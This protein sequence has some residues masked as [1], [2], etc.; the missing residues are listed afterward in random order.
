MADADQLRSALAVRVLEPEPEPV[1]PIEPEAE[2]VEPMEPDEPLV[3]GVLEALEPELEVPDE[4]VVAAEPLPAVEP[5]AA[6][7]LAP[8]P[9]V[10]VVP[11]GVFCVLRW[12]APTAGLLAGAGGVLCANARL[13]VAAVTAAITI[14]NDMVWTPWS[15]WILTLAPANLAGKPRVGWPR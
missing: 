5:C 8:L 1:V 10:P 9:G 2:L 3:L 12:P 6:A 13:K 15:A 7:P 11:I 4:P 14:L